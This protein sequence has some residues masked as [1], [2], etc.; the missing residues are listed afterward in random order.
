MEAAGAQELPAREE[1][2][3]SPEAGP[4]GQQHSLHLHAH[5]DK[6]TDRERDREGEGY[7]VVV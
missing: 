1:T 4:E 7:C 2:Q 6:Q 5:T 3:H